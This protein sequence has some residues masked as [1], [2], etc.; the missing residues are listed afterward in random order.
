MF[1]THFSTD[2]LPASHLFFKIFFRPLFQPFFSV[3]FFF[4]FLPVFFIFESIKFSACLAPPSTYFSFNSFSPFF[5]GLFPSYL[6]LFFQQILTIFY[7]FIRPI[8]PYFL[9]PLFYALFTKLMIIKGGQPNVSIL[10]GNF[11]VLI[12]PKMFSSFSTGFILYIFP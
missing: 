9:P 6:Q 8:F 10:A 2:F 4:T 5:S 11:L 7:P 12:F 3:I 1:F